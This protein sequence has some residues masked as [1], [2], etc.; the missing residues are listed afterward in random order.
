LLLSQ[1]TLA[2]LVAA[3][4]ENVNRA[5]AALIASGVVSQRSGHFYV[6]DMHALRRAAE[7]DS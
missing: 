4:R 1:G 2:A 6:H 7:D 3:S 5:L